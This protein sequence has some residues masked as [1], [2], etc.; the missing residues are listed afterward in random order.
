MQKEEQKQSI[1]YAGICMYNALSTNYA[2]KSKR[3]SYAE[4]FMMF[5]EGE[6]IIQIV[7]TT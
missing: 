5:V 2:H 6:K 1:E 7:L 3:K 4:N